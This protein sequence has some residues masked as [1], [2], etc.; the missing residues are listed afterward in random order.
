MCTSCGKAVCRTCVVEEGA[1]VCQTCHDAQR[2]GAIEAIVQERQRLGG[3]MIG[4]IVA[5]I[6]FVGFGIIM[7][8]GFRFRLPKGDDAMFVLVW[9]LLAGWVLLL[10]LIPWSRAK[11]QS[12][13]LERVHAD[14]WD[15]HYVQPLA[16]GG[17][18]GGS[19]G[20]VV[21]GAVTMLVVSALLF[22][23]PVLG[24]LI[25]G[26]VGGRRAGG[27]GAAFAAVVLPGILLGA[28]L[29]FMASTVTGLP[30]IGALAGVGGVVL[31]LAHVGPMLLGACIGG[32]LAPAAVE[33]HSD[34]PSRRQ[35]VARGAG[36]AAGPASLE[37][38]RAIDT[39]QAQGPQ[40]SRASKATSA[41]ASEIEGMF[42]EAEAHL[43][44]GRQKSAARVLARLVAS[45]P[46]RREAE[47]ARA[48]LAK[49]RTDDA[50]G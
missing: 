33:R 48:M 16:A 34:S 44:L 11:T 23:L 45:H 29:F 6:A 19:Q 12:R 10:T 8:A 26:I 32:A 41:E 38:R 18:R 2:Q 25:A 5:A 42:R 37:P 24:A 50:P 30:V 36:P 35:D 4:G 40:H 27:V 15:G 31:S 47:V 17:Q 43:S 3:C 7:F 28:G 14:D 22:W 20:S 9:P 13:E 49:L 46:D 39:D 21:A 1:L